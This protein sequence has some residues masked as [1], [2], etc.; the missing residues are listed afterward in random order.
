MIDG[1]HVLTP[2]V[3]HYGMVGL[4]TYAPAVVADP[5]VVR[6]PGPAGRRLDE[7]YDQEFEDR[8]FARDPL[9]HR[10]LPPVR[11]RPLHRRPR[12]VRRYNREQL[13]LRSP[14]AARAGRG[15]RR[16][17]S[18]LPGGGYANLEL[19]ERLGSLPG[20]HLRRR[21]SA[22][23][24]STSSTAARPPTSPSP[25]SWSVHTKTSTRRC[26]DGGSTCR[27]NRRAMWGGCRPPRAASAHGG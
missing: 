23:G 20:D 12:L 6:G 15:V 4:A 7:G 16:A 17:A 24:R 27:C 14:G 25:M 2:G 3:L 13:P 8:L 18:R 21:S 9:A 22:K 1:A 10:R 19:Y 5:A 11:D 26:G